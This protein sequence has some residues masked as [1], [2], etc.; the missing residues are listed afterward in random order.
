MFQISAQEN[1]TR[2]WCVGLISH[3]KAPLKIL[4]EE[5]RTVAVL[6][7]EIDHHSTNGILN[8]IDYAVREKQPREL[9]LDF[10]DVGFMDSSDIG[11]VMGRYKLMQ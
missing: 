10:S 3:F 8:E 6:F 7:G 9:I 4:E 5:N 11:L 1:Y 2:R